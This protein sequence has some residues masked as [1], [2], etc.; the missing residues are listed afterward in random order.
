MLSVLLTALANGL[1]IAGVISLESLYRL[2]EP[3]AL[4]SS[5]PL[6]TP[7][8][9]L[10]STVPRSKTFRAAQHRTVWLFCGSIL[11]L[12]VGRTIA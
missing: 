8:T 11:L 10:F 4:E 2:G 12:L 3:S 6:Y 7:V 5:D 9:L 1:F